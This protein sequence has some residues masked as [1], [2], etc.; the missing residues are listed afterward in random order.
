MAPDIN[1]RDH[2]PYLSEDFI[3]ILDNLESKSA[4]ELKINI[5]NWT[6]E[7]ANEVFLGISKRF[8]FDF[9]QILS[10]FPEDYAEKV[11]KI[12]ANV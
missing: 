8:G 9:D 5:L 2:Y 3:G 12:S 4:K 7:R 11:K 1:W 6:P 10:F